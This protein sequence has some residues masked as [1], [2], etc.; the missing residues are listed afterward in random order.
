MD[1]RDGHDRRQRHIWAGFYGFFFGRRRS[2]R[3]FHDNCCVVVDYVNPLVLAAAFIP[4]VLCILDSL[5]TLWIISCGGHEINPF[6]NFFIGEN[7]ATF[8]GIKYLFTAV[9][10]FLLL[11]YRHTNLFGRL[12]AQHI[13]YGICAVYFMLICYEIYLIGYL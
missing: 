11:I 9:G 6:M 13:L 3:R 10:V 7:V 4:I 12:K 8:F 5:L 1:R 2:P